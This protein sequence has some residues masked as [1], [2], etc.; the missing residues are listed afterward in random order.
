MPTY[1]YECGRCAAI[2]EIFHSM[3]D[4]STR[5]CPDCGGKLHRHVGGAGGVIRSNRSINAFRSV[6]IEEEPG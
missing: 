1:R 5:K 3:S 2:H 4:E 6:D